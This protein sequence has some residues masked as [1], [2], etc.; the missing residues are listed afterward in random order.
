MFIEFNYY[1]ISLLIGGF[2]AFFS[3]LLVL[4]NDRAKHFNLEFCLL[5]YDNCE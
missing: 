1:T 2:M 5:L 4:L 3:G